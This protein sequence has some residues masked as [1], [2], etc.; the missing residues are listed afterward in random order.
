MPET[1][2]DYSIQNDFTSLPPGGIPN[3]EALEAEI[4]ANGDIDQALSPTGTSINGDTVRLPFVDALSPT[5]K[6]A[7]DT[8]VANHT[9]VPLVD[10][11]QRQNNLGVQTEDQGNWTTAV[12]HECACYPWWGLAGNL[13]LR[14]QRG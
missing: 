9:G 6:T 2:Y 4:E 14:N 1:T 5:G 10:T 11:P 13:V 7:L 12:C 8:V 3:L